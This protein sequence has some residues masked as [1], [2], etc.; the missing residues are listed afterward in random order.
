M[1]KIFSY[2]KRPMH[3]GPYPLEKLSRIARPVG[4]D[5]LA[6]PES[7][8]FRSSDPLSIDLGHGFRSDPVQ[9]KLVVTSGLRQ[10]PAQGSAF[11]KAQPVL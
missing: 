7:L 3:L 9:E 6:A 4:L 11:I 10:K 2:R 1:T 8:S 5:D